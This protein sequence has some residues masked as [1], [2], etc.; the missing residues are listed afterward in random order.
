MFFLTISPAHGQANQQGSESLPEWA[1]ESPPT[2]QEGT[3]PAPAVEPPSGDEGGTR[4]EPSSKEGVQTKAIPDGSPDD[5]SRTPV[6]GGVALLAAAGAGYAV[7]KLSQE[8]DDDE[9]P[10]P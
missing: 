2:S 8:G 9:E 1:N 7:R 4:Q 5:P 6:D 3:R 10:L